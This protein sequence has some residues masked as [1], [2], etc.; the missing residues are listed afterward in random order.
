MG[1]GALAKRPF[2]GRDLDSETQHELLLF[3]LLL[4]GTDIA[5]GFLSKAI[6]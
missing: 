5:A 3:T 1:G 4:D 6:R 2:E